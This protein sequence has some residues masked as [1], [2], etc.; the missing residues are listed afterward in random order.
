MTFR[1]RPCFCCPRYLVR[2]S[3]NWAEEIH[4]LRGRGIAVS[5]TA[6]REEA[7][8][9]DDLWRAID[10]KENHRGADLDRGDR[11]RANR[12]HPDP[13]RENHV[14]FSFGLRD[15]ELRLDDL[16]VRHGREKDLDRAIRHS[17]LEDPEDFCRD[18][19]FRGRLVSV[20]LRAA[21][22]DRIHA[23]AGRIDRH[24]A[25]VKADHLRRGIHVR[26]DQRESCVRNR[27]KSG[28]WNL[29]NNNRFSKGICHFVAFNDSC[30]DDTPAAVLPQ[31]SRHCPSA[32]RCQSRGSLVCGADIP[33]K[34][35]V[36]S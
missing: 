22:R 33:S 36:D 34:S 11:L 3:I 17:N 31:A 7:T 19:N 21:G 16:E 27:T 23:A 24:L 18:S 20:D 6:H 2:R 35:T 29:A 14:P 10:R 5:A 13:V 8:A 30:S 26:P 15:R 1:R 9:V 32:R 4:R 25:A 12:L 28:R